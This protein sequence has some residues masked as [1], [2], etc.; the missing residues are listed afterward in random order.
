MDIGGVKLIQRFN[1][2]FNVAFL[3]EILIKQ[4]LINNAHCWSLPPIMPLKMTRLSVQI[5]H[6]GGLDFTFSIHSGRG[7]VVGSTGMVSH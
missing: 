4:P 7:H 2:N 1:V 3:N 5:A 6:M